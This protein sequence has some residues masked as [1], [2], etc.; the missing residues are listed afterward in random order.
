MSFDVIG[1]K[2]NAISGKRF[3]RCVWHWPPLWDYCLSVSPEARKVRVGHFNDGDG[4]TERN[5]KKLAATLR[6]H[7]ADGHTALAVSV[8]EAF[9]ALMPDEPCTTCG[10]TGRHAALAEI[11]VDEPCE[12]CDS[13]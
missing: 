12:T 10:G 3:Y 7:L 2:P 9:L 11:G 13:K 6:K 8:R 4:L 5:S 1:R